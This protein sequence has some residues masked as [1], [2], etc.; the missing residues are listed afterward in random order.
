MEGSAGGAIGRADTPVKN[1]AE[2]SRWT[3][4]VREV[5]QVEDG[6]AGPQF[7]SFLDFVSPVQAEI[8]GLQP[9]L[10][11]GPC[12]CRLQLSTSIDDSA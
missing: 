1:R 12:G 3:S 5:E 2:R 11:D 8:E 10:L 4:E 6:N 7:D 9:A